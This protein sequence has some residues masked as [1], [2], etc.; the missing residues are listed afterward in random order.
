MLDYALK[1]NWW[2]PES[3]KKN[4]SLGARI[5]YVL[6]YGRLRELKRMLE[7]VDR[8]IVLEIWDRVKVD[9]DVKWRHL[10]DFLVHL[11]R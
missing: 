1:Y 8:D 2:T 3:A 9:R 5:E 4:I 11:E 6:K 7:E 10:V